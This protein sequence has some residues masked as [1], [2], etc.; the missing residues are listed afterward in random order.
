MSRISAVLHLVL[1]SNKA[2]PI[3]EELYRCSSWRG[4]ATHFGEGQGRRGGKPSAF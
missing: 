3:G 1:D 2:E 4:R